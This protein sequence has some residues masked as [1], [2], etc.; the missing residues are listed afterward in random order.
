MER[1]TDDQFALID[2]KVRHVPGG[3]D[4]YLRLLDA[5]RE[6]REATP[7]R[8]RPAADEARPSSPEGVERPLSRAEEYG[9]KKELASAER[10]LET[11]GKK[12]EAIRAE[13][14]EVDPSDYVALLDT[15]ERLRDMERQISDLED[16]WVRISERLG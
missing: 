10:K 5:R 16:E 13:M 6:A 2:G 11:L 7:E 14:A 3:V 9:L 8:R 1:V 4:E 15:Q 12:A